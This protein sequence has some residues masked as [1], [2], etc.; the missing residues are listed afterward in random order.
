MK[1]SPRKYRDLS[2]ESRTFSGYF[3]YEK[4]AGRF[5]N[6][7]RIAIDTDLFLIGIMIAIGIIKPDPGFT[8]DCSSPALSRKG[9]YI[10][11]EQHNSARGRNDH[12]NLKIP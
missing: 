8:I 12:N 6:K 10:R 11:P 1:A 3:L 2:V 9:I 7:K 5:H 4:T